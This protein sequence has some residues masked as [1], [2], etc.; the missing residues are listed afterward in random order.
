MRLRLLAALVLALAAQA[1]AASPEAAPRVELTSGA[2]LYGVGLGL[3]VS[4][5]NDLRP[6][7]AAWLTAGLATG[8]LLGTWRLTAATHPSADQA[9][10]IES[11]ALWGAGESLLLSLALDDQIEDETLALVGFGALPVAALAAAV[12]TRGVRAS[13]GQTMLANSTG[14]WAPVIGILGGATF[15]LGS[16]DHLARD[17]LVMSSVGLAAGVALNQRYRPTSAEVLYL[18]AGMLLGGLSAELV[19]LVFWPVTSEI[20]PEHYEGFT[21]MALAGMAAGAAVALAA[22]P[23]TRAGAAVAPP[24]AA[25]SA[26]Q[27]TLPAVR[28]LSLYL[29]LVATTW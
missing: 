6:R 10:F 7:P 8:L 12:A 3:Y 18:D 11:T 5:E 13:V 21:F 20:G 26:G 19:S 15:H 17:L 4:L 24:D 9:R 25:T 29:P 2:T 16:G 28:S 23:L 1:Q 27:A 22:H 14:L